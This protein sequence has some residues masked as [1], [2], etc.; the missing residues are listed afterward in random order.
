MTDGLDFLG[1][2]L[3]VVAFEGWNDAG[4]AATGAVRML[5]DQLELVPLF[6]V[7]PELYFDFQFNRP[8]IS[9]DAE[10]RKRLTWPS[11]TLYGP[12]HPAEPVHGLA[13]DAEMH[14]SGSNNDNVYLLVG[15]EPS[16]SWKAFCAELL[17]AALTH[18][19]SA[20]I[21]LGAMLA[22]VPHTRPISVFTSSESAEVRQALDIERSSYEGP[23]GVLS[24]LSDAA[25]I[26]DI[27]TLSIWASVPHYVQ[28]SPSPKAMLALIDKLEELVDVVIPRG[29]LMEQAEEWEQTINSLASDDEEMAAYIQQLEAARDTV[30]APEAS[31]EAIARE[32][33]RYL[34]TSD[35]P[36]GAVSSEDPK[37]APGAVA[38]E[39]HQ[40]APR[41]PA[42]DAAQR[43]DDAANE[44]ESSVEPAEDASPADDLD[45]SLDPASSADR[46]ADSGDEL[47]NVNGADTSEASADGDREDEADTSDGT[48]GRDADA[49][50]EEDAGHKR[51]TGTEDDPDADRD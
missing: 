42:D 28:H 9:A 44:S 31:G 20:I 13:D 30:E 43:R 37:K 32:F 39:D 15:T 27:P 45:A 46:D 25:D 51:D 7:D 36:R 40:W 23:V 38:S 11:A 29:E 21:C 33:E 24:A 22:D 12:A 2:R 3:L 6:D 41:R 26:L 48:T 8:V 19:I 10:G 14:I 17:D 47:D 35:G 1:G 50:S 16:R 34:R 49:D 18:D 5:K 4:D